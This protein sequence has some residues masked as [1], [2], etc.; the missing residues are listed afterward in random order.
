MAFDGAARELIFGVVVTV[1]V[2]LVERLRAAKSSRESGLL[3]MK[4]QFGRG[5]LITRFVD[6]FCNFRF[7]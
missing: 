4:V 3:L 5:S 1:V 2:C 6:F 7:E